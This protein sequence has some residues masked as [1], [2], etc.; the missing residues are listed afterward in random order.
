MSVREMP[1]AFS[2][3]R[4]RKATKAEGL[5]FER[6]VKY[7]SAAALLVV[8][9]LAA[10]FIGREYLTYSRLKKDVSILEHQVVSLEKEYQE[11]TA[12]DVVLEKANKLGLH[13]PKKE[14]IVRLTR[15]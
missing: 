15:P 8:F 4:T 6:L 10:F 14:Q 7:V 3:K 11:L 13:P 2:P 9:I 12:K 1:Y 5:S